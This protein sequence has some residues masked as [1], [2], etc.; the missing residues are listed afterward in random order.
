MSFGHFR[1]RKMGG[2]KTKGR[3]GGQDYRPKPGGLVIN[4]STALPTICLAEHP[5]ASAV[6]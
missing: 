1:R 5:E 3:P 4:K 6:G 2:S